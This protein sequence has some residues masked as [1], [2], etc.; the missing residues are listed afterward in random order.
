MQN[1]FLRLPRAF[2]KHDKD[3]IKINLGLGRN[4]DCVKDYG[5]C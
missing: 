3:S 4:P 5:N 2:V 1:G